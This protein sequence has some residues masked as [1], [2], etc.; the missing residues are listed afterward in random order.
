MNGTV[1]FYHYNGTA[2]RF[3]DQE[4]TRAIPNTF[5]VL[6]GA[7]SAPGCCFASCRSNCGVQEPHIGITTSWRG[8][9]AWNMVTGNT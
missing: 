8:V 1:F 9:H 4:R 2:I 5:A 6:D 3:F 7:V